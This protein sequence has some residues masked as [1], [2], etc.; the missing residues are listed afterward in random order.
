MGSN[1][2]DAEPGEEAGRLIFSSYGHVLGL[3]DG[4]LFGAKRPA[5]KRGTPAAAPK[6]A[7]PRPARE[8]ATEPDGDAARG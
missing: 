2:K 7:R 6:T 1:S 3:A 5:R 8:T 4:V